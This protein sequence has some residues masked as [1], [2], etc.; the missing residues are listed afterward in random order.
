MN[1]ANPNE[2]DD[3]RVEEQD[4]RESDNPNQRAQKSQ[5]EVRSQEGFGPLAAKQDTAVLPP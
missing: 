2:R 3:E 1:V 5:D 4:S